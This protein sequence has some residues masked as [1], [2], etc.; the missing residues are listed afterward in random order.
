MAQ[1]VATDPETS[2]VFVVDNLN[3]HGSEGL[4]NWVAQTC[5]I[6]RELGKKGKRGILHSQATRQEFLADR[7]A[8]MLL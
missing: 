2:W 5:G 4:V 1:T 6:E 3:I 8:S 7:I